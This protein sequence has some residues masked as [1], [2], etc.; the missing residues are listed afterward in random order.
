MRCRFATLGTMRFT[1]T[2][3]AERALAFASDWCSRTGHEELEPQS[4][5]VGLLSEPECRAAVMLAKHGV[6]IAAV[7]RQWPTL[8]PLPSTPPHCNGGE[9]GCR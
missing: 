7:C 2:A 1:F 4:L 8:K 9:S 3:A 5:L 6:D